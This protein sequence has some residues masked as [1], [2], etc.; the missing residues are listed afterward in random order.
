MAEIRKPTCDSCIQCTWLL[1]YFA[2]A[3]VVIF[4]P[5]DGSMGLS[6][7]CV[8]VFLCFLFAFCTVT[9]L[10]AAKIDRGVKFCMYVL[11]YYPDR[12]SP[13]LEVKGQLTRD[14]KMRIHEASWLHRPYLLLID[15]YRH[16][17]RTFGIGAGFIA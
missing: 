4:I 16:H 11:A 2:I 7:L 12:S 6:L 3:H 13:I 10:S 5:P 17:S 1:V 9:D 14:K 15:L 8:F